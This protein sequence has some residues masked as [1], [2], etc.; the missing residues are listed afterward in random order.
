MFEN[1]MRDLWACI[2]TL[3]GHVVALYRVSQ[4]DVTPQKLLTVSWPV[5]SLFEPDFAR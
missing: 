2:P 3:S 4:K 1:L 5:L